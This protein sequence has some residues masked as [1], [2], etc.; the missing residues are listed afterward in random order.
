MGFFDL[1]AAYRN[2]VIAHGGHR[3]TAFYDDLGPLLLRA[4]VEVLGRVELFGGLTLAVAQLANISDERIVS[5]GLSP[6]VHLRGRLEHDAFLA[7]IRSVDVCVNLRDP[8][9]GETSAV[10]TQALQMGTP[11]IAS[12]VGWY[13]E[14]P[15]CV[16]KVPV[17]DGAAAALAGHISRLANDREGL[18]ELSA[19][20]LRFATTHLDFHAVVARYADIMAELAAERS[21]RRALDRALYADAAQALA[22]LNLANGGSEE[23][24]RTEL[25]RTL[26]PCL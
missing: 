15:E 9:M 10:V 21:R 22:D 25:L 8:T 14:L 24:I 17:G 16:L 5:L 11:V 20:T 23:A 19:A 4:A 18:A 13:A 12:D 26:T 7:A 1:L 2:E 3:P 6:A